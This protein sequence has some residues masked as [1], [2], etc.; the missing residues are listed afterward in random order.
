[1]DNEVVQIMNMSSNEKIEYYR[2][3][4]YSIG[5]GV[6]F[7]EHTVLVGEKARIADGVFIGPETVMVFDDLDIGAETHIGAHSDIRSSI[8]ALGDG[9]RL[10]DRF[11]ALAADELSIGHHSIISHDANFTA[12]SISIG[13]F[14]YADEN[15][16]IG[17]GGCKGEDSIV[18]IGAHC[19]LC[20]GTL[21]NPSS[22]IE[23]GDDVGIGQHVHIWTHGGYLGVLNGFPAQFAPVKIGNHVWL[24]ARSIVLPGVQ[25]GDNVVIGINSLINKDLPSGVL[26]AGIPA[27]VIREGIYPKELSIP[28]KFEIV[29]NML[30]RYPPLL[31][32]KNI[33]CDIDESGDRFVISTDDGTKIVMKEVATKEDLEDA[34]ILLYFNGDPSPTEGKVLMDLNHL[35]MH[36]SSELA[37]DLRDFLRRNGVKIY[38][39]RHFKSIEPPAFQRLKDALGVM[40]NDV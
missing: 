31:A 26:A 36:G 19:M 39:P 2:N 24:P 7:G 28:E 15:I 13:P 8:I 3:K 6:T 22:R 29:G 27:K 40:R 16:E 25:I 37:E 30:R 23:I 32:W 9:V 18:K 4:G 35:K 34:D 14:L 21:L 33:A 12:R 11:N 20:T 17:R 38:E 1:M 10:G 5:D